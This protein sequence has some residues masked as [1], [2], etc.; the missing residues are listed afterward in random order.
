MVNL[1]VT[2]LDANT[3]PIGTDILPIVDDPG[4]S[5][6]NQ[7]ITLANLGIIDGW[8][9]ASESWSY[10]SATTIT[11]PS[12]AASK[13]RVGDKI[14]LTQ[15]TTKYFS[16]IGVADT[17]LTVTGGTDF[18]VATPTAITDN[19]YSH[20]ESPLGF[21]GWFNYSPSITWGGTPPTGGTMIAKF[22]V[23]CKTLTVHIHIINMT[24]GLTNNTA[25]IPLPFTITTQ[26]LM[27][28]GQI[29]VA[30]A[31]NPASTYVDNTTIYVSGVA[32]AATRLKV[33]AILP[34]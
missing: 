18:T 31:V 25:N 14:K 1:K 11:V 6:A 22:V 2:E 4:G 5:P 23:T 8:I 3:T 10:A 9:P 29:S 21:P 16:I 32:V 15:T 30:E 33:L 12:G 20:A 26:Y 28:Y 17:V 27:A 34:I 19:Y 24:A 7:K 13:Y